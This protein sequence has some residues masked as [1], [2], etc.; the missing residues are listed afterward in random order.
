M[1]QRTKPPAKQQSGSKQPSAFDQIKQGLDDKA[2]QLK[3][4]LPSHIDYEQFK[5]TAMLA[6]SQDP[7]LLKATK[8]SLFTACMKAAQDGLMPDG[9]EAALVRFSDRK[10]GTLEA[11]Y[12]PMMY[13]ILKKARQSGELSSIRAHVVYEGDHF[14][15]VL[16]DEERIEHRP[17]LQN[18]GQAIAAYAIADLTNGIR[19]REV[20]PVEEIERVR[21]ASR[22]KNSGPWTQ[23]W[24][25]MA[26]K[27]VLRRLA[28]RLPMSSET[29]QLVRRDDVVHDLDQGEYT[30]VAADNVE[31]LED[32]QEPAGSTKLDQLAA[33]DDDG[34]EEGEPPANEAP[35]HDPETG[36][37]QD[38][39]PEDEAPPPGDDDVM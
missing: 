30:Q 21:S 19:E 13:G 4:A 31:R 8:K 23:W 18:R 39:P 34:T 29:D 5:N 14:E 26:R 27:T 35:P 12:M 32:H 36:E 3:A 22:T 6:V 25:E 33:Q 2:P 1:A 16:G 37:V 20:M 9:R 28:K 11:Q 10:S 24:S 15:Y 17:T 38:T 7:E